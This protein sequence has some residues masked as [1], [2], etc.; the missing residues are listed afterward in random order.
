MKTIL[1]ILFALSLDAQIFGPA[2]R[3][4]KGAGEPS[5][6]ECDAAGDVG[7][8]YERT[9]Q[10]DTSSNLRT[11]SNT[12]VGTYAWVSGGGGATGPTGPTGPTGTGTTGA[13]G[14]T[15]ADGATGPT[16]PTGAGT[17]GATGP[18]GPTG[19]TGGGGSGDPSG[20]TCGIVRTSA[21]R[22]TILS[23][24][25]PTTPCNIGEHSFTTP[26]TF[27]LDS[28]SSPTG[29]YCFQVRD[30]S[31]TTSIYARLPGSGALITSSGLI[32]EPSSTCT[33][34]EGIQLGE[35]VSTVGGSWDATGT[36]RRSFLTKHLLPV[37]GTGMNRSVGNGKA[38]LGIDN[39]HVM[40]LP[41][42]Q[43]S[44][45][46]K[47]FNP[48]PTAAGLAVQ[49]TTL[50]SSP[51]NGDIACDPD[52][53]KRFYSNGAWHYSAPVYD[54]AYDWTN[55]GIKPDNATTYLLSTGNPLV[56]H[57]SNEGTRVIKRIGINIGVAGSAS[58]ATRA[59]IFTAGCG[60]ALA[61]SD[62]YNGTGTGN[63]ALVFATPVTLPPGTY[64]VMVG[65]NS[66]TL[67]A[68]VTNDHNTQWLGNSFINTTT[69]RAG[70]CNVGMSGSGATATLQTCA[71]ISSS[72]LR[73]VA[74]VGIPN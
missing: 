14:P 49:C 42:A 41:D 47:T 52:G 12:G 46:K 30:E 74:M 63:T 1:L 57:W 71:S 16:G 13:T 68:G 37:A 59:G 62:A 7:K 28:A 69:T 17:T 36:D 20:L 67:T 9:D 26:A 39:T 64:C 51:S 58:E 70:V 22:L 60:T 4:R 73:F 19:P 40:T 5:A 66:T 65:S 31:G 24:A 56:R 21:S 25:S 48:T 43:T 10:G 18:T 50:P 55:F 34:E 23:G 45:A 72:G 38:T 44:T 6:G 54:T 33:S 61:I 11:C 35:W 32:E 15:G 53:H 2:S 8:I 27:D 29:T 3:V